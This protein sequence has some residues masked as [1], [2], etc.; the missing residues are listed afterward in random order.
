MRQESQAC[1]DG[2]LCSGVPTFFRESDRSHSPRT[3]PADAEWM[4]DV[5]L[6][7][8]LGIAPAVRPSYPESNGPSSPHLFRKCPVLKAEEAQE[9]ARSPRDP[10]ERNS[11]QIEPE[12]LRP[13]RGEVGS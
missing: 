11:S 13:S 4:S 1:F 7:R 5:S 6:D 12:S 9:H 3:V 2:D 8:I 10:S